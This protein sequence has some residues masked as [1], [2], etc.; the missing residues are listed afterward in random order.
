MLQFVWGLFPTES[1]I[2]ALSPAGCAIL[3]GAEKFRRWVEA[4]RSS[5]TH[6]VP[7]IWYSILSLAPSFVVCFCLSQF[8]VTIFV[9]PQT[10]A[11]NPANF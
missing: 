1:C 8:I 3:E 10:Q 2:E 5:I 9:L 11:M 7:I 6:R 4:G